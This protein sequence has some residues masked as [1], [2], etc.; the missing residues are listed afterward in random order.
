[1]WRRDRREVWRHVV[2]FGRRLTLLQQSGVSSPN[3]VEPAARP[4]VRGRE[5]DVVRAAAL[6]TKGVTATAA[7][8]LHTAQSALPAPS[9]QPAAAAQG[10]QGRS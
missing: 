3:H 5:D 10:A 8:W 6:Q 4:G 2:N 9:C 7:S 1:M